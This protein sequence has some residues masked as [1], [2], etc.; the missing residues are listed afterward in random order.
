MR[1]LPFDQIPIRTGTL[2]GNAEE[3]GE[4]RISIIHETNPVKKPHT[5]TIE[6]FIDK[7]QE[8]CRMLHLGLRLSPLNCIYECR[9]R[10][11]SQRRTAHAVPI[12]PLSLIK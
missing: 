6:K 8:D 4:S 10:I 12:E 5:G 1:C 7:F 3:F 2:I 9:Q 11:R